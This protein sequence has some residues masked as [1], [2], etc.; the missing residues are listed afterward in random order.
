M[1]KNLN[2]LLAKASIDLQS[3]TGSVVAASKS[4]MESSSTLAQNSAHQA[5]S[6]Q[7]TSSTMN[8]ASSMVENNNENTHKALVFTQQTSSN[9]DTGLNDMRDLA[10]FM[11][12]LSNSGKDIAKI[13]GT[14]QGIASRT[15]ILSLNAS[16]E[17]ARAG[18]Y[19]KGFSVVAQEVRTLAAQ[20]K[21]SVANTASLIDNNERIIGMG[22]E[23]SNKVNGLFN[24]IAEQIRKIEQLVNGISAASKEQSKSIS[25][26][27]Q[28]LSKIGQIAASGAQISQTSESFAV[29]LQEQSQIL[30]DLSKGMNSLAG[31]Y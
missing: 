14:I 19:G 27:N 26:I 24:S 29:S 17:A 22:M 25:N 28:E 30:S 11:N 18:E 31:N 7:E 12:Q 2:K 9:I 6:I 10:D 3:V 8:E 1:V 23:K 4:L 13:I 5:T 16:I 21:A 20:C 15:N